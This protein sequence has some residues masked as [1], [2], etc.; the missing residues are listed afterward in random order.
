MKMW[1]AIHEFIR[2]RRKERKKKR[3]RRRIRSLTTTRIIQ[4]EREGR[5]ESNDMME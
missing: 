2:G 5:D 4:E 1:R 3:C